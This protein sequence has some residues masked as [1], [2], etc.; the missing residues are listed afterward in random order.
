MG[1]EGEDSRL[2]SSITGAFISENDLRIPG[3]R[4]FT[5]SSRIRFFW[6][7]RLD[8]RALPNA[9]APEMVGRMVLHQSHQAR[10]NSSSHFG[11]NTEVGFSMPSL[12]DQGPRPRPVSVRCE[13]SPQGVQGRAAR[14]MWIQFDSDSPR[15]RPRRGGPRGSR[16]LPLAAG[17]IP[18]EEN[19]DGGGKS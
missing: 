4:L 14:R 6:C 5:S 3:H 16:V 8:P 1:I 10:N 9:Q 17:G 19:R 12:F 15:L 7:S 2:S 13:R 18:L 11:E